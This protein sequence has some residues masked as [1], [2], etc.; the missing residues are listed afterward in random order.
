MFSGR[1]YPCLGFV[2][3]VRTILDIGANVGASTLYF[4]GQYPEAR[5]LAF[6]PFTESYELLA[7]NVQG[8]SRISTFN[9][10]LSD[11][12]RQAPL[13]L[14]VFDSVTNSLG[15]S[16][17]AS[18][19]RDVVVQLRNSGDVLAEQNIT[20]VDILKLD[21]EGSELPILRSM[22]PTVARAGVI[23]LEFHSEADRREIDRML[24]PTHVLLRGRIDSPH[25]GEFCY[26]LRE[27]VPRELDDMAIVL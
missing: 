12:D 11:Q 4:A 10:G 22:F 9:F 1:A 21:T 26:A 2:A 27:R 19:Q 5:I 23:Y 6:E 25:R 16:S 13:H 18:G 17:E 20:E 7:R 15:H 8:L 24:S 14:G 3:G